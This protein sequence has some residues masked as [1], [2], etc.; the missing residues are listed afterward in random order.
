MITGKQNQLTGYNTCN[1]N[2]K[3]TYGD[4]KNG[5]GCQD[6][7]GDDSRQNHKLYKSFKKQLYRKKVYKIAR[8]TKNANNAGVATNALELKKISY[9]CRDDKDNLYRDT[10]I[11]MAGFKE[12]F[13]RRFYNV[14]NSSAYTNQR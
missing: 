1:D 7:S 9:I 14:L 2:K 6:E 12:G 10:R 8:I 3:Y 5:P 11:G 4:R 13:N